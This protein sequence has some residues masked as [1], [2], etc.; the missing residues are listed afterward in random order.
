VP[1]PPGGQLADAV[2]H[3]WETL[4]TVRVP[5]IPSALVVASLT[6]QLTVFPSTFSSTRDGWSQTLMVVGGGW[7][8]VLLRLAY[9]GVT[10]ALAMLRLLPI[11]E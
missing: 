3:H 5:T 8:I 7:L 10:N 1:K 9:L 2:E 4:S 6:L 11:S